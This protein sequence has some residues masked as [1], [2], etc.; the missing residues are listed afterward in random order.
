M[1]LILPAGCFLVL[2]VL[3]SGCIQSPSAA[4]VT[5]QQT[6]T[7]TVLDVPDTTVTEPARRVVTVTAE[8]M[9][10]RVD[11]KVQGGKDTGALTSLS[12]RIKNYDGTSVLRN[13]PSPETGRTYSIQYYRNANAASINIVGT[14]SDGF[15]Q[16]LL[17]NSL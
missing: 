14:F 5:P 13:I 1:R 17:M 12:V 10:D 3:M 4:P 9:I 2:F 6:G 7:V 11:I 8:K 16:T 15:Q